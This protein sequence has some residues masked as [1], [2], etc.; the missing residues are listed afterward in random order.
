M[1]LR[2][3][4][5]AALAAVAATTGLSVGTAEAVSAPP[6][7]GSTAC[8]IDVRGT[9]VGYWSWHLFIVFTDSSGRQTG[10]RGGPERG[11]KSSSSSSSSSGSSSSGSSGSSG[12]R[13]G[14]VVMTVGPYNSSFPDWS[15]N[16]PSR[17][18]MR[19]AG[20]CPKKACFATQSARINASGTTYRPL[21]P[22]SN[23]AVSSL[24]TRCGVPREKPDLNTPGWDRDI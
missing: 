6:D 23:S 14:N 21:G 24:L 3:C 1:K 17:T 7:R 2:K 8:R 9:Y 20:A 5:V 22:N 18:V 12:G 15:P 19:G 11:G 10:F 13:Y 16:A 4:A